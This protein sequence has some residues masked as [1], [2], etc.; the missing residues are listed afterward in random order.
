MAVAAI[1][2]QR[3][4]A[5][6]AYG[7]QEFSDVELVFVPE[8]LRLVEQHKEAM[9]SQEEQTSMRAAKRRREGE[10]LIKRALHI[11]SLGY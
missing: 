9:P 8:Q 3:E 4:T 1:A 5:A 2:L 10:R 7:E 11:Y 6:F